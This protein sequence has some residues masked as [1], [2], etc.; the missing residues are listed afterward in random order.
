MENNRSSPNFLAVK[1]Y[2]FSEKKKNI[3][4]ATKQNS[5]IILEV[6]VVKNKM[7]S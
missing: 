4:I 5:R 6:E 7:R 1:I 3:Y 2:I